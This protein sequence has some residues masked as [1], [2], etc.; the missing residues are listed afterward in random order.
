MLQ[1]TVRL[2]Y[3]VSHTNIKVLAADTLAGRARRDRV[4]DNIDA[5]N[6][7]NAY[8]RGGTREVYVPTE[9]QT[10]QRDLFYGYHTAT[11]S[12]TRASN[13][14]W[15][16]CA[17]HG[18]DIPPPQR[19]EKA[20]AIRTQLDAHA[21]DDDA[22]FHITRLLADYAHAVET[23]EAYRQRIEQAV[24]T[25]PEMLR[26]MQVL[27]I[28]VLCA[29]GL[30]AFIG[31][32]ERFETAKHL[33]SY[34]GL[35]PVVNTSGENAGARRLSRFG[36]RALKSMLV[37]AAHSA[38]RYGNAPMHRWARRKVASGK[39]R[40]VILCAL[41]RKMVVMAWHILK[42][43]PVPEREPS[44]SYRRKLAKLATAVRKQSPKV[45]EDKTAAAFAARVCAALYPV[46]PN[47]PSSES[48]PVLLV[49]ME[50][51]ILVPKP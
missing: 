31:D 32:V 20:S 47:L 26:V 22:R 21:W 23:R 12:T 8:A 3:L 5:R 10:R 1:S 17:A 38:Y 50:P 18:F 6:L 28:G 40:N 51:C 29:F 48:C 14:L 30:T 46:I 27:G 35:N 9:E 33:V 44:P 15:A 4:N 45:L 2:C 37:E 43:H 34:F 39:P 7:A 13:H 25:T 49:K 41:A 42:G 11:A 19:K 36:Q 16:F 24:A